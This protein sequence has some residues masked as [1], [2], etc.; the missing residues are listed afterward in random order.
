MPFFLDAAVTSIRAVS[1]YWY[2]ISSCSVDRKIKT[3]EFC[4]FS[5]KKLDLE[6]TVIPLGVMYFVFAN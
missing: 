1:A 4:N 5:I 6:D 2:V 3:E